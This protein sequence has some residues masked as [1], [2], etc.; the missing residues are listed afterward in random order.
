MIC[1]ACK[2]IKTVFQKHH[3]FHNVLWARKL[4]KRLMDHPKN[5][6]IVC[7]DCNTSHAGLNLT[8]WTEAEFCA[9]LKIKARS[10]VN[11]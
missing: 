3:Q 11:R 2:R 1:P 8:H 10:K 5:I 7:V 4:Y 9:A 6:Q